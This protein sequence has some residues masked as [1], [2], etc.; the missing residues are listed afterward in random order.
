MEQQKS[1]KEIEEQAEILFKDIKT[2][3][4]YAKKCNDIQHQILD[5]CVNLANEKKPIDKKTVI[6]DL[7][8]L[9]MW[10]EE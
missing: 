1:V 5:Y 2:I 6:E 8:N 3:I 4:N 7:R 9:V 10:E